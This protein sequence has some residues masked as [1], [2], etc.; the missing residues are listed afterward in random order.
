MQLTHATY[1]IRKDVSLLFTIMSH[2]LDR[3]GALKCH[4]ICIDQ[5]LETFIS[6]GKNPPQR[7]TKCGHSL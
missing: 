5:M 7:P 2:L 3:K 4:L 1:S 6:G